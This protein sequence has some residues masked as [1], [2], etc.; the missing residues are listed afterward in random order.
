MWAR[1]T[2]G[3]IAAFW[4]VMMGLLWRSEFGHGRPVGSEIPASLVL[5]K[6]LTAPD[7]STL[8]IRHGTNRVGYCRWRADVGQE[9]ATG[10]RMSEEEEPVEGMVQ[11]LAY[12]TLDV[13]GNVAVADLPH[14]ARF[15]FSLRLDTNRVWQWFDLRITL[16]PDVYEISANAAEQ[17][18][19][20]HVDAGADKVDRSFRFSE[21]QNPQRL[22]TEI[23]GPALPLMLGIFGPAA[24]GGG[25]NAL[26]TMGLKWEAH[27]DALLLGRNSVRAYRLK[28]TLFDRF[29]MNFYVSPVGEILRVELPDKIVLLNDQLSALRH[30]ND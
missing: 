14:R 21:F 16:R 17:T 19:K 29:H 5:D 7:Q 15:V 28:G 8:E 13:D 20:L 6:I 18:V 9:F 26:Q 3:L 11:H 2:I 23:G 24:A 22:L 27:N 12:Y 10:A 4:A 1:M 30:S 25:T